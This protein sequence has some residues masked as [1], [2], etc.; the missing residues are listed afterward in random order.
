MQSKLNI[1]AWQV[2]NQG[3]WQN[4]SGRELTKPNPYPIN[5]LRKDV[6]HGYNC[7]TQAYVNAKIGGYT[8]LKLPDGTVF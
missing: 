8:P 5:R 6:I 4:L 2:Q 7:F 3:A 1:G